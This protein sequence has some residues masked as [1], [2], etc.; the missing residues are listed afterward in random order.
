MKLSNNV[1]L[2]WLSFTLP[3]SVENM[4]RAR[5]LGSGFELTEQDFG[6]FMYN[7]STRMLDG[8][9]IYYNL[10]RR[11]MGI[12]VAINAASLA[13]LDYRPLQL[14][15][16]IEDWGGKVKRLD[17]AFD[18]YG[19]LLDVD[20]MYRKISAGELST[21]FRSVTRIMGSTVGKQEKGG[22]TVNLGRRGSESFVRIY[23]KYAEQL[24]KGKKL[25]AGAET[26]V[27]VELELK[28]DK[29]AAVA[30]ILGG[31]ALLSG[32]TAAQEAA[33]LLYGLLDFK[34]VGD[35]D[36]NKSRWRTSPWW[37]LFIQATGKTKLSL[38]KRTKSIERSK[39]WVSSQVSATLAMIILSEADDNGV[40]GWD[41]V[42]GCIIRGEKMMKKEQ[43][44][45][46][47]EY[48]AQQREKA[49][50]AQAALE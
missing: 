19:G 37:L 24:S 12:H 20:E 21:R 9:H 4:N 41:F 30:K 23:D 45:T 50:N 31:S 28:G 10:S 22:D 5:S 26:W 47:E 2:D 11:D 29:A 27:R 8:A 7:A 3:Y 40:P 13:V 38:P 48:N 14:I 18:D 6:R 42:V 43:R 39:S 44:K 49:K 33:N 34:E 35:S 36:T 17:L 25:P 15:N 46:L 16:L 32:T 1:S